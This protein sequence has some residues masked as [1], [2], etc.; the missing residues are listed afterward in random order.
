MFHCGGAGHTAIVR[1]ALQIHFLTVFDSL[2]WWRWL[3]DLLMVRTGKPAIRN[4]LVLLFH[5]RNLSKQGLSLFKGSQIFTKISKKDLSSALF[6]FR[7]CFIHNVC[8]YYVQQH[9]HCVKTILQ[10]PQLL[11]TCVAAW[12]KQA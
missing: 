4:N 11:T 12:G 10:L 3:K 2:P 6:C 9:V 5:R 1:V 8:A 7:I